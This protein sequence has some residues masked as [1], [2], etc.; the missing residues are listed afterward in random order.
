MLLGT[1]LLW[2]LNITVTK[3]VLTHG[4][5]PLAYGT[6][7][8]FA[9]IVALL[10]LHLPP[11]AVVPDR[12]ERPAGSS[13]LAAAL[14]FVNQLCFV[15]GRRSSTQRLDGRAAARH[16]ADLHRRSSRRASGSSSCARAFWIGAAVSFVGVG[17]IA[18]GAGGGFS[19]DLARRPARDRHRRRPGPCYSVAIAPLM[20]R[21]SPFRISALVLAI[22]WVPLALVEH[23][24]ARAAGASRFG[25][26][27]W[28][29]FGY[30]VIGPLFL[31]NILWFTAIDRVGP[32]R[33]SLFA[34]LQPFFAVV[35]ALLLLSETLTAGDRR[36]RPHLRRDRC[37]S[38]SGGGTPALRPGRVT[39]IIRPMAEDFMPLL[40]WDYVEFW[41][42]N[43][44][45]AAFFYEHA[46]GFRRT[47]YAGP[48]TG[49][50]D[51]A[52]YVLEQ[53]DI[54][55]V[56]TSALREEHE[57][58]K[59]YARHGDGVKDIAL[60]RARRDR[61]V[62]PGGAARRARHR[63]AVPR[64]R[65]SSARSSSSA[66]ATYGDTIHTFVNRADYAGPV[67]ARLRVGVRRTARRAAA[68]G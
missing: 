36:R 13:L 34:N 5:Q 2:A 43:A 63:R 61:G 12:A 26:T 14:I 21:Y 56:V 67:Q 16:D 19:A 29:G 30:A 53:G 23:P 47:A 44:K 6:I 64:S 60:T 50:R 52:S 37:S 15:Y 11:R 8:Y 48:E 57:I 49:V 31:T 22:G 10:G 39:G 68:S 9:A 28:L 45:Q 38:G 1:V 42:G 46:L 40:G 51:R 32:S 41:V 62:P 18:A 55:F 4:F 58:T 35:F 66:I 17:L 24:A 59:H 54:R 65:T 27:I 33:A 7:R 3:Y 20:R 25:W